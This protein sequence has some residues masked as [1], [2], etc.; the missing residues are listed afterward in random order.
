M[1]RLAARSP[2]SISRCT[3]ARAIRTAPGIGAGRRHP[4]VVVTHACVAIARFFPGAIGVTLGSPV[5]RRPAVG[6]PLRSAAGLGHARAIA[7]LIGADTFVPRVVHALRHL[8]RRRAALWRAHGPVFSRG[9]AAADSPGASACEDRQQ[10]G[11]PTFQSLRVHR[12]PPGVPRGEARTC[13]IGGAPR[14]PPSG[15]QHDCNHARMRPTSPRDDCKVSTRGCAVR[16]QVDHG[17]QERLPLC[18]QTSRG[19][20]EPILNVFF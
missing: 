6:R 14:Q 1:Q 3:P 16:V 9:L 7:C 13:N 19:P 10:A 11:E 8:Q 12:L 4:R 18:M 20:S 5:R 2:T 15:A 17:K